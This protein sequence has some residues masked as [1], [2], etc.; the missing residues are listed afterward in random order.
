[1]TGAWEIIAVANNSVK[2][3]ICKCG[4]L[5]GNLKEIGTL[6]SNTVEGG[7]TFN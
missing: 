5:N 7:C 4:T 3:I 6:I 1:M 2:T